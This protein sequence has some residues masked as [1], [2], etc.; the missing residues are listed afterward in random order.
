M[1]RATVQDRR[2]PCTEAR[3]IITP[4]GDGLNE[5]FLISCVDEFVDNILQVYNRHG[6][7]VFQAENYDNSWTGTS[8][9]G[10]PLP[11]GPYYYVLEYTDFDGVRQQLKGSVTLLRD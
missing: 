7:L 4:D 10:E 2:F 11:E 3:E 1:I 8:A 6:Q 9:N 5:A